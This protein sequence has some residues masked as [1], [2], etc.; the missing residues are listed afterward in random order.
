M[1]DKRINQSEVQ[2]QI[3]SENMAKIEAMSP[4]QI[5]ESQ[6]EILSSLSTHSIEVLR[7][8]AN[9]KYNQNPVS[10]AKLCLNAIEP[11]A[12]TLNVQFNNGTLESKK[13]EWMTPFSE[14]SSKIEGKL[15]FDFNGKIINEKDDI[16][17]Y[18]GLHH[19]GNEPEKAG[20]CSSFTIS[21]CNFLKQHLYSTP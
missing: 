15:R 5:M 9:A 6:T 12:N 11:T 21:L 4:S 3:H 10:P 1:T 19:H 18:K 20:V 14:P 7:K 16:P 2:E 8:R 17:S 13:L